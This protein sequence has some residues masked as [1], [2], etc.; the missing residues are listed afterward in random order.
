MKG[1]DVSR[2]VSQLSS[3]AIYVMKYMPRN[4]IP[5]EIIKYGATDVP[6]LSA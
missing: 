1:A 2:A 5:P 6:V 4:V 3:T